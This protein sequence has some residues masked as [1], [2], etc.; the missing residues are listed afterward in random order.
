MSDTFSLDADALGVIKASPTPLDG[1]PQTPPSVPDV[2]PVPATVP[3]VPGVLV[4]K[5]PGVRFV[6]LRSGPNVT[7]PDIGDVANGQEIEFWPGGTRD[8]WYPARV[9]GKPGWIS[10]AA[11]KIW[12]VE[13]QPFEV[14]ISL[15]GKV[16]ARIPVSGR[17]VMESVTLDL[18][19]EVKAK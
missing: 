3:P 2:V 11:A 14:V 9:D 8:G 6:N 12:G 10:S 17:S 7:Y 5:T 18:T 15:D 13:Q 4:V 1:P 19:V 16:Y